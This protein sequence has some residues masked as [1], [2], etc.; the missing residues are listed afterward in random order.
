MRDLNG[1][2]E[3]FTPQRFSHNA[4]KNTKIPENP[5]IFT[6]HGALERT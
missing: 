6:V 5:G 4:E 1:F 3:K 2:S